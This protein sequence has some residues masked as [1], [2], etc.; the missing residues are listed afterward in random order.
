MVQRY[1]TEKW[2]VY[3]E[4]TAIM[5]AVL[6]TGIGVVV[7][8]LVGV[9]VV[10]GVRADRAWYSMVLLAAAVP[11]WTVWWLLRQARYRNW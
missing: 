5:A 10:P 7:L 6:L 11:L 9:T 1:K 8:V 3:A 4:R 2:V